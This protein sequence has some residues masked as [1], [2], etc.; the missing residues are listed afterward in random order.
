MIRSELMKGLWIATVS[1]IITLASIG[2]AAEAEVPAWKKATP[3]TQAFLGDDGGGVNT[4]TVCDTADHYRDW[5]QYEH[6]S[7]CQTLQHDLHVVI[8]VVTLDPVRDEVA[9]EY[10]RPIAKVH[11]PSRNFI[12]YLPLDGLHP[13][14]PPGTVVKYKK[15]GDESLLLFP[16]PK[17]PTNNEGGIDLGQSVSAKVLSYDP[18]NDDGFDLN[19]QIIDGPHAGETGWMLASSADGQ[20]GVP[21]DLFDKAVIL[22]QAA[23]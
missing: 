20:D 23:N 14:I 17:S 2:Y 22:K 9:E 11:I 5:L 8:E 15:L 10:Y 6:P 19:L 21:I 4:A 18:T 1:A 7:G 16:S 12:G 13:I 3:G